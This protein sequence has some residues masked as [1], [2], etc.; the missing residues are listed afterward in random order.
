MT[1]WAQN[2]RLELVVDK[3]INRVH[4]RMKQVNKKDRKALRREFQG[5]FSNEWSDLD[6]LWMDHFSA[7]GDS[8]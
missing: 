5:W 2:R 6:I 8:D 7:W 3:T 4:K 1:S